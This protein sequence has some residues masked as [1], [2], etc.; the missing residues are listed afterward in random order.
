MLQYTLKKVSDIPVPSR[1][2][3]YQNSPWAAIIKLFPPRVSVSDIPAGDG[4]VVSLFYSVYTWGDEVHLGLQKLVELC[5]AGHSLL[6]TVHSWKQTQKY[7]NC[8]VPKIRFMYS[9]KW[10]YAATFPIPK[11]MYVW[12]IY[13][14]PGSV[15][16]FG[17]SKMLRPILGIYESLTDAWMWK[18]GDR[19]LLFC[20]G[21][22]EAVQFHF[23]EHI[24]RNQTFILDS[25][26]PFICSVSWKQFILLVESAKI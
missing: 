3:P 22:N 23:W 5:E 25:H 8:I 15:C 7:T 16:L 20:L 18:L 19:T 17:F 14:F 21:N 2:V 11:F 9:Q 6:W 12:A 4:T 10:N 1:D 26:R 24:N 13:I